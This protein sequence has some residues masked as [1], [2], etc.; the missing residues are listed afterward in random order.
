M[1]GRIQFMK[2]H[3]PGLFDRMIRRMENKMREADS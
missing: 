3:A 2:R 1:A